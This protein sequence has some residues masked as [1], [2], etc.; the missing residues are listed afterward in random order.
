MGEDCLESIQSPISF[1]LLTHAVTKNKEATI[2]EIDT[3]V[4]TRCLETADFE[5]E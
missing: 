1:H 3:V 4:P 5:T 2:E